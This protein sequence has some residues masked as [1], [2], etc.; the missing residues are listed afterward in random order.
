MD[1]S[2]N[3]ELAAIKFFTRCET[4][5]E[6]GISDEM[7]YDK[8]TLELEAMYE[9]MCDRFMKALPDDLKSLFEV[10]CNTALDLKFANFEIG[11]TVGVALANGMRKV[12]DNPL[13]YHMQ[14]TRDYTTVR[15]AHKDDIKAF[16]DAFTDFKK[17]FEKR[18]GNIAS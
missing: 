10:V 14:S 11:Q 12:L 4:L 3:I 2:N 15:E 6:S 17:E 16:C 13:K 7:M 18:R 5:N 1:F 8:R 9:T